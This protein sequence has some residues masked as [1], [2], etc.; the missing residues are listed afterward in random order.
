MITRIYFVRH[1]QTLW[2]RE[3]R[4]QGQAD[5]PLTPEGIE[6]ARQL[7]KQLCSFALDRVVV[8]KLG[9]T[10]L[11]A[12]IALVHAGKELPLLS[13]DLFNEASFSQWQGRYGDE[14]AREFPQTFHDFFH[15][16][17]SYSLPGGETYPEVEKRVQQGVEWLLQN[18]P[19][20]NILVVTHGLVFCCLLGWI[21][22]IPLAHFRD[23][24]RMP[25]NTEILSTCWS[26]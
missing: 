14:V 5:T 11:T 26:R 16:P 17:Q 10:L 2:N 18:Y 20:E 12:S 23:R 19:G 15:N 3:R 9:R 25:G 6:Q 1:A 22:N 8:S 21:R 4:F 13:L 24:I 7:G